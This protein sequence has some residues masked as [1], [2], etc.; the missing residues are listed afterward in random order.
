[1]F[2]P[3]LFDLN[4]NLVTI[5]CRPDA[6]VTQIAPTAVAL[7]IP[8]EAVGISISFVMLKSMLVVVSATEEIATA[9]TQ[10]KLYTLRHWLLFVFLYT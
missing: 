5:L 8:H 1:M 6:V 4:K 9:Q 3:V 7:H 10:P 2:H